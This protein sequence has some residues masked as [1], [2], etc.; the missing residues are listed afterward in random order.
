MISWLFDWMV[1]NISNSTTI[2]GTCLI[3][4][5]WSTCNNKRLA[6]SEGTGWLFTNIK[7]HQNQFYWT[8]RMSLWCRNFKS[9]SSKKEKLLWIKHTYRKSNTTTYRVLK[10]ENCPYQ[11]YEQWKKYF[12]KLSCHLYWMGKNI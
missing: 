10:G 12:D 6:L 3:L 2:F 11:L 7:I 4:F 5:T 9:W 8:C 1:K